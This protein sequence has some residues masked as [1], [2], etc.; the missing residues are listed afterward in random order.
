MRHAITNSSLLFSVLFMAVPAAHAL[1]FLTEENPPFNYTEGGK[2]VGLS[3]EIVSELAKR[4]GVVP[5]I[6]SLPWEKAYVATQ[7]DKETCLYSTVRLDN[8]ERL[9]HW[10]GP[11]ATNRWVLIGKRDFAGSV[12]TVE[13][14]KRYRVGVVA[15]DAKVEFLMSKGV[16]DLRE[17]SDDSMN[18]PRLVLNRDDPNRIDL[19]ATGAYGARR[20]A[21]R[22]KVK[23][24]K[25][26]LGLREF[27]LYLACSRNTSA[28]TVQALRAAFERA[29]K[30]G[31]LKR[32]T[33]RHAF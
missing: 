32:I 10:I 15:K 14:A 19:W 33:D 11:I 8:R 4:N 12:K 25:L 31:T 23:D 6:K 18:P 28:Q 27:P 30:D 26:V 22:A 1:T 5:E 24:L 17:V 21:E 2:V 16:T 20:T 3:T 9:F 7:A 29:G 13:D